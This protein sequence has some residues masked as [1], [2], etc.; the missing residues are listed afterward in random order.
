MEILARKITLSIRKTNEAPSLRNYR[1][2]N[3]NH[4]L[5]PIVCMKQAV[6]IGGRAERKEW[7]VLEGTVGPNG[8]PVAAVGEEQLKI[9][10][11]A[12]EEVR[13]KYTWTQNGD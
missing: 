13:Y 10:R 5:V 3:T 1:R 12:R 2:L 7:L 9:L 11:A 8:K 6:T 4:A